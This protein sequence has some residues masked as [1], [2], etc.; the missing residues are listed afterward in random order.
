MEF[1]R[2]VLQ[3]AIENTSEGISVI[4]SDLKLVA[5]NKIYL[6]MFDYPDELIYIGS[7][8]KELIYHNLAQKA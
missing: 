3:S 7:P 8:V 1:S 2:N 5:W 4:D 6:D